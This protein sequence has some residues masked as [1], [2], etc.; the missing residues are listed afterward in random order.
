VSVLNTLS[1]IAIIQGDYERATVLL[2]ES[3]ALDRARDNPGKRG[4]WA[5]RDLGLIAQAQGDH[6]RAAAQFRESLI[7]RRE[8]QDIAGIAQCLASLAEVAEV[9]KQPTRAAR[10]WGAAEALRTS[11]G[12]SQSL[13][14]RIRYECSVAAARAQFDDAVFVAAWPEGRAMTLEQAIAYALEG[15]DIGSA[16]AGG[17]AVST[18]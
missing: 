7:I 11:S 4:A 16:S 5:L 15:N 17:T 14:E 18:R 13:A 12:A 3:L 9:Q 10:L 1:E 6:G 8:L 2:E